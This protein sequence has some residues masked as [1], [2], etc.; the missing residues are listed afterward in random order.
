MTLG[1]RTRLQ[2]E[3]IEML[4]AYEGEIT[5]QRLRE[6]FGVTSVQASRVLASYRD[7]F[8]Y[9]TKTLKGQGRGRYVPT[10]RFKP[11]IADLTIEA[12]FRS[13]K[14]QVTHVKVEDTQR[15]FTNVDPALFR[16]IHSAMD[17]CSATRIFYRSMNNPEGI[18]RV[19]HPKA[20]VFA[21]RRWHVRGFDELTEQHRDFNLARISHAGSASKGVD[22][23]TDVEWEEKVQLEFRPHPSLTEGQ[24]KLIRDELFKGTVGRRITT[25]RALIRYVLRDLEA[26]ENPETQHP[27]EFQIYLFRTK[28]LRKEQ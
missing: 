2:F 5:N 20:F 28:S 4:L 26:A 8:P 16:V 17:Q 1:N 25:R 7:A 3:F 23:P 15:D 6:K 21:G 14:D 13:V 27:P 9:N 22:T 24:E 18:E 11:E 10:A 12:Y 19:V